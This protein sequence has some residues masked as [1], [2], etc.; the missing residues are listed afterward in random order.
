MKHIEKDFHEIQY[1]IEV[2]ACP[3]VVYHTDCGLS[4]V[5]TYIRPLLGVY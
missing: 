4:A 2:G 3:T 1:V 5:S